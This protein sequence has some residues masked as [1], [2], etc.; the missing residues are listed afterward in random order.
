MSKCTN[1][2]H[3]NAYVSL[4]WVECPEPS[5]YLNRRTQKLPPEARALVRKMWAEHR[6]SNDTDRRLSI[7]LKVDRILRQYGV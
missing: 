3:P 4:Q 6:K 2:G 5:C 7:A 1:C